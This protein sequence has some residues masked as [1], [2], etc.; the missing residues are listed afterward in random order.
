LSQEDRRVNI[1]Y[2]VKH[3]P[4]LSQTFVLHE[5]TSLLDK[6]HDVHIVSA[7]D[8]HEQIIHQQFERYRLSERTRYLEYDYLYRYAP[9]HNHSRDEAIAEA[10]RLLA[11]NVDEVAQSEK[12]TL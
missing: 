7:I 4:C 11:S 12:K 3:F 8:L 1:L 10:K 6:G 2:I 9:T 5:I